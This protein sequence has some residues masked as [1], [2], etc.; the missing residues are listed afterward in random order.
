MTIHYEDIRFE[1][2]DEDAHLVE[3]KKLLYRHHH[4]AWYDDATD[5]LVYLHRAVMGD[6]QG[7]NV[8][9]V[10]R[11]RSMDYRKQNLKVV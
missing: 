1:I 9:F 10:N 3:G 5:K 4:L 7:R 2:D 8:M 11:Y 6:P